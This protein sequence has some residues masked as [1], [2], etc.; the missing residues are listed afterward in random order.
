MGASNVGT[1]PKV[2]SSVS[3]FPQA[4]ASTARFREQ[5]HPDFTAWS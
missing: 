5:A 2:G 3:G 1:P 4:A